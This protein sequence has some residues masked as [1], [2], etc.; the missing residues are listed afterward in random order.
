VEPFLF[1]LNAKL[2]R[3]HWWYVARAQVIRKLAEY[4]VPA[5]PTVVEIGCGTGGL[6]AELPDNWTRIGVDPSERAIE[7]GR[8]SYPQ[9]ELRLGNA[10][11]D[12]REELPRADLVLI[13]DVLEH[14]E[15]DLALFEKVAAHL[16][17]G[18]HIL[19]TVPAHPKL[20]TNHDVL[21]GHVRRYTRRRVELL[22]DR[23][24][25]LEVSLFSPF[26]WRL[27]PLVR[28]AR[29]ASRLLPRPIGLGGS[30]LFLP[31]GPINHILGSVFFSEHRKL[32]ARIGAPPRKTRFVG[33]SWIAVLRK[34]DSS[35]RQVRAQ[36]ERPRQEPCQ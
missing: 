4:L 7:L 36:G 29:L 19:L 34:V 6:L 5:S 15:N 2:E 12:V 25:S 16:K 30:D 20:W 27:Y 14:V 17:P 26:N 11:A 28:L 35:Q 9:L 23:N 13:C 1:E 10:P 22:W 24:G 18:G 32:V 21:H 33:V 31:P 3:T 8:D